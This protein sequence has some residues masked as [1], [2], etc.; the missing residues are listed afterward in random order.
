M[1]PGP[2]P[3]DQLRALPLEPLAERLGYRRRWKRPGSVLAIDGERFFDHARSHGGGG[4]IDLVMHA[5]QCD[6]RAALEF[7]HFAPA[8]PA[9]TPAAPQ[10]PSRSLRLPPPDP[11]CWP[12]VRRYLTAQ[13]GL[14]PRL[15]LACH[16]DGSLYADRRRNAV[17]LCRDAAGTPTGAEIAGTR[18]RAGGPPFKGMAPGSRK[19]RGGFHLRTG[20][21]RPALALLVES[22]IDALSARLLLAPDLPPHTLLAATA[23]LASQPPAWI[24]R[25]RPRLLVCAYDNDLP[26]E[27]AAQA[28]RRHRP[29][30]PRLLPPTGKDC[31][32]A[33]RLRPHP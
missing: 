19:A 20:R 14:D 4:A 32:D 16:R 27:Q 15:L 8:P 1:S 24:L 7:L 30:L 17:F 13:R 29:L 22:A 18:P 31:N 3:L 12:A 23:G 26:G 28:L 5:R 25:C 11:A 10:P 21:R 9:A 6:F 33:L 2:P